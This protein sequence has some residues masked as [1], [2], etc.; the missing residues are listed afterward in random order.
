MSKNLTRKGLALG[1]VVALGSSLFAGTPA[2]AAPGI[3]L[4]DLNDKGNYTMLEGEEFTFLASGN[5]DWTGAANTLRVKV[6]NV[7]GSA[8]A[9]TEEIA[10]SG[11]SAVSYATS[12]ATDTALGTVAAD[13]AVFGA[14]SMTSPFQFS[15]TS[16]AIA[17]GVSES[18]EVQVWA[19]VNNNGAVN[20]GEYASPVRTVVFKDIAS[21]TTT[22][23]ID[24]AT[25]GATT[26]GADVA[27]PGVA[28][29]QLSAAEFGVKF[30]NGTDG[31]LKSGA[32]VDAVTLSTDKTKFEADLSVDALVKDTAV[33][34]QLK[35]KTSAVDTS[36][37][38][39]TAVGAAA[40]TAVVAKTLVTFT[41]DV[42]RGNTAKQ[43]STS[44]R[45]TTAHV[46]HNSA[47]EV[48]ATAADG[49][50]ADKGVAGVA[51]EAAITV[52]TG[53]L[54]GT[55][56]SVVSLTVNGTTYTD[57]AKLPGASS[58]YGKIKAT[59]DASGVAKIQLSSAGLSTDDVVRVVFTAQNL[60]WQVDVKQVDASYTAY[61]TNAVYGSASGVSTT[62]GAAANVN[63]E[64]R[65]QFGGVPADS[66]DAVA[67]FAASTQATTAATSATSTFKAIV[68]GKAT[69]SILDDGTGVGLNTYNITWAKRAADGTRT[70][71][72][73][74]KS[75]FRV[76]IVAAAD[77]VAGKI[78]SS[79]TL[80]STTKIYENTTETALNLNDTGNYDA[81]L[82]TGTA[83]TVANAKNLAGVV[84]VAS[85]ATQAATPIEGAA[86]TITGPAGTQFKDASN[87]VYGAGSL[88]VYTNSSGEYSINV[89]SNLAGTQTF[90]LKSGSA[91][92][93]VTIKFAAA[94]A[95]TG[96][97]LVVDAPANILPGRT[98][99]VTATLKD[100]YG[101]PVAVSTAA[102]VDIAW[103]GP[104]L[105]VGTM[106]DAFDA[107]GKATFRVLLGA[108]ETGS[109][110]VTVKY[111]Q[112]SDDDFTGTA[113]GDLDLVKTATVT[114]GAAPAAA[115]TAAVSGSTG[116][117]FV[118]AT[119]AAGKSVV[120]KVA[121]KFVT[122]F[123]AT[124]SKKSVAVKATKGSKKV[125]VFVGGKLVAT[126]TVTV[127]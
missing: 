83:P 108:Y 7:S 120:V 68:G 18:Y 24:A 50:S 115:A 77:L 16:G 35:W 119:A 32:N 111:D 114:I 13:T 100:K 4:T 103:A 65:D 95:T 91:T 40:T 12:G 15:L 98:L 22:I 86:L 36:D 125:T 71:S 69:L 1:A 58:T 45:V 25:E 63:V 76:A 14:S 101:N 38:G 70:G 75:G 66:Y 102:D 104:G 48:K 127:K 9:P 89:Y 61:I 47:Y 37:S 94:A 73:T 59:T 62:D 99:T 57:E 19:D 26:V 23:A 6:K 116:K 17:A 54:S 117:F 87:E 112:S 81:R 20:D 72:T 109:G 42:V 74:I 29:D 113:T 56:G 124:G 122:S 34:A 126:K 105:L 97:S 52:P 60:T 78:T 121:G 107:D 2:F 55:A 43:A 3:T 5:S 33:K 10:G 110:T 82:A 49:T 90:T 31:A 53:T 27:I 85:S 46:A 93:V 21:L 11:T 84:S 44:G 106:V 64:V 67:T 41:G 39:N 92:Q 123:K 96:T 51:V 118:S 28:I 79:G 88:T 30:T 80:N 8:S